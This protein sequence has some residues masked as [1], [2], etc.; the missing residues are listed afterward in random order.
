[1]LLKVKPGLVIL[2]DHY[3][4]NGVGSILTAPELTSDMY[5]V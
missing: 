3:P 1:M 2:Y 5:N 4:R